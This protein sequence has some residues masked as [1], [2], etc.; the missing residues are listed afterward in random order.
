[1]DV[2]EEGAAKPSSS[3][4]AREVDSLINK[5]STTG[6]GTATVPPAPGGSAAG[7]AAPGLRSADSGLGGTA[8]D[9]TRYLADTGIQV[10]QVVS[11]FSGR[12]ANIGSNYGAPRSKMIFNLVLQMK[13]LQMTLYGLKILF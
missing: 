7:A 2:T 1:M 8:T 9:I 6:G 5:Y 12:A 13:F 4:Q 10:D 3:F 11:R